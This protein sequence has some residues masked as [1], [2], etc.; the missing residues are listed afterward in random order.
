[1][2]TRR[3]K[4]TRSTLEKGKRNDRTQ[5]YMDR[6][7]DGGSRQDKWKSLEFALYAPGHSKDLGGGG[8]GG[9]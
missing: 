1:M 3:E 4:K 8:G 2:D 7:G 9:G 6:T 5:I